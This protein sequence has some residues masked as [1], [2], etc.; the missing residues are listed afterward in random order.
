MISP[1][2]KIYGLLPYPASFWNN[3]GTISLMLM[4]TDNNNRSIRYYDALIDPLLGSFVEDGRSWFPDY[5]QHGYM[6]LSPD[7]RNALYSY[8]IG[9]ILDFDFDFGF[10]LLSLPYKELVENFSGFS[11]SSFP[12]IKWS[13]DSYSVVL[14]SR[15]PLFDKIG[16]NIIDDEGKQLRNLYDVTFG[17]NL[18]SIEWSPDNHYLGMITGNDRLIFHVFDNVQ[19]KYKTQCSLGDYMH[20]PYLFWSPNSQNIFIRHQVGSTGIYDLQSG[21][22]RI[23]PYE[24]VGLLR[25]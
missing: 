23:L 24:I 6:Q 15:L 7:R 20:S 11:F 10:R 18:Y 19:N 17:A 12:F 13:P 21:T 16:I 3:D 2:D 5:D 4:S 8:S 14:S 9:S 1:G 25:R 22:M